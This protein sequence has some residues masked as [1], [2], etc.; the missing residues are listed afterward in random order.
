M[1][2]VSS[3]F[4]IL[5]VLLISCEKNVNCK[6]TTTTNQSSQ[7]SSQ[8]AS[9]VISTQYVSIRNST[10]IKG[11]GDCTSYSNTTEPVVH[12]QTSGVGVA[13]SYP[14]TTNVDCQIQ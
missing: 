12:A 10:K 13:A 9:V 6:C 7:Q 3:L 2:K 11:S 4:F 8:G 5:F 14:T 1:K